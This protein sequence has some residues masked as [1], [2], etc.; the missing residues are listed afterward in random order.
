MVYFGGSIV[1]VYVFVVL[2]LV[3]IFFTYFRVAG[4]F[5]LGEE[6]V[7]VFYCIDGEIDV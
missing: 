5:G 3:F 7:L 2:F 4:E 1:L 6:L